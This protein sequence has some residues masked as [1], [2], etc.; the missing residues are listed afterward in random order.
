MATMSTYELKITGLLKGDVDE[1]QTA[2]AAAAFI[3]MCQPPETAPPDSWSKTFFP[4]NDTRLA[5]D[6]P[7]VEG[8]W[9]V[10]VGS[11]LKAGTRLL[12][13]STLNGVPLCKDFDL[14]ADMQVTGESVLAEGSLLKKDS[15]LRNEAYKTMVWKA[16][17]D[18]TPD[19]E[20]GRKP[21]EI[22][23]HGTYGLLDLPVRARRHPA[24][25]DGTSLGAADR[26]R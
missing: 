12:K 25:A 5:K 23:K 15:V 9:D 14:K 11:L 13:D 18:H 3:E 17:L 10:M 1:A 4:L 24:R 20:L 16:V 21:G 7:V 19:W 6:T 26:A 8:G 2:A 22:E